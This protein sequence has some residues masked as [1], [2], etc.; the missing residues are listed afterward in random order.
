M[1]PLV[2]VMK[3][4]DGGMP[5]GPGPAGVRLSIDIGGTFTDVALEAGGP[6]VTTKVLTTSSAPEAG[7][8]AASRS[9]RRRPPTGP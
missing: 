5:D 7:V 9:S 8:L 6:P 3:T 1:P 2:D 4:K